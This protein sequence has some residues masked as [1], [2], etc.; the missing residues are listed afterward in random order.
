MMA[1]QLGKDKKSLAFSLEFSSDERTLTETE[2]EKDF[3]KLI[4]SVSQKFNATLRG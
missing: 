4:K 1:N 3:T 2:V